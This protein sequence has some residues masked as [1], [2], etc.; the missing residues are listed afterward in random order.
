MSAHTQARRGWENDG[1]SRHTA[2]HA[3]LLRPF[4]LGL[5]HGHLPLPLHV[6]L[7]AALLFQILFPLGKLRVAAV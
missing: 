3:R 4:R 1:A 5:L 7:A 6:G 2:Y